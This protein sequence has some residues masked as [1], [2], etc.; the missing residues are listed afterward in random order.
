MSDKKEISQELFNEIMNKWLVE[1]YPIV[2][3]K[4]LEYNENEF[5]KFCLEEYEDHEGKKADWVWKQ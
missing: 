1:N 2:L 4:F 5:N 3:A